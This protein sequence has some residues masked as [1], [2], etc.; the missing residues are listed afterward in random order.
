MTGWTEEERLEHRRAQKREWIQRRRVT[1]YRKKEC[2]DC[3]QRPA[4]P[5][6]TICEECNE[7]AKARVVSKREADKLER[8]AAEEA[9]E[10]RRRAKKKAP[11]KRAGGT[12]KKKAA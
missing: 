9:A 4:M 1:A 11:S 8:A 7:R 12:T 6:F 3:L 2:V 10:K 5:G